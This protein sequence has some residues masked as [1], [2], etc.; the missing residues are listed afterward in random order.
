MSVMERL[1]VVARCRDKVVSVGTVSWVQ[2]GGVR[3]PEL[4][5]PSAHQRALSGGTPPA[6]GAPLG[7][8]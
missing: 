3:V 5:V 7:P 4:H 1:C 8:F 2:S 6:A